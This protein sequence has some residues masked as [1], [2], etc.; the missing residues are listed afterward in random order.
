[1]SWRPSWEDVVDGGAPDQAEPCAMGP[2]PFCRREK[3]TS[4]LSEPSGVIFYIG[5]TITFSKISFLADKT[6]HKVSDVMYN[7][8]F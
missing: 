3:N 5:I 7:S 2:A 1:M 4:V 6:E 8:I